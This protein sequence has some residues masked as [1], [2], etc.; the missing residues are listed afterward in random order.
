M[1]LRVRLARPLEKTIAAGHPWVYRDALEPFRASPGTEATV[2]TRN[3]RFLARGLV[4]EG[5]IGVRVFT[6]HDEPIDLA[7]VTARLSL[8]N[9]LR[10]R[11]CPEATTAL[12]LVHGEGDRVPGVVVDRYGAIAVLRLDGA[13]AEARRAL[14]VD[15]VER[16]LGALGVDTLL[17]R[18]GRRETTKV[19]RVFGAAPPD[20]VVVL[21]RGAK[22]VADLIHGQKTGL[23]LD[24]REARFRVRELARGARVLNLY[25]YTGGFSVNAAL[26]GATHVTTVDVAK[27][28][29]AIAEETFRE[30]GLDAS[31]HAAIAADVPTF[32]ADAAARDARWDLVVADPPSFAPSARAL[33]AARA[34]YVTLHAA[35]L[36]RLDVG[37]LYLA[38]SCSSHVDMEAFTETLREGARRAEVVLQILERAGAP[39]DHPRLVAFPEG[40]YLKTVLAR[41]VDR[42]PRKRS[43]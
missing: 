35:C 12:R 17:V 10:A 23:F 21:E 18:T 22:L 37:G 41:V 31:A 6:L 26:G 11:T 16:M 9:A 33:E 36:D 3:G 43:G 2:L 42:R 13:A 40:D 24:H 34:S 15:A 4:D 27:G 25:G 32:L 30:N 39:A 28:A 14:F 19:E 7:L 8:A 38:G 20:R 1:T 29:I 5:P